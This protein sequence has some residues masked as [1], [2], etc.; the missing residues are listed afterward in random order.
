MV[1]KRRHKLTHGEKHEVNVINNE[2]Q[3]AQNYGENMFHTFAYD[4]FR[5]IGQLRLFLFNTQTQTQTLFFSLSFSLCSSCVH[6]ERAFCCNLFVE[7]IS[8]VICARES[9]LTCIR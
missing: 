7:I 4:I 8:Q 6:A 3:R 5:F 9:I 2:G 1:N